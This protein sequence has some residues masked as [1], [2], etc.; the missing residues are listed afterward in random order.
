MRQILLS[1][2]L[3][4]AVAVAG[5]GLTWVG[6]AGAADATVTF[7]DRANP[8]NLTVAPGTRVTFANQSGERMRVRSED[9]PAGFDSGNLEA[10]AAWSVVL[11]APGTYAYV[12]DRDRD[13]PAYHG[14]ITVSP[15]TQSGG[16]SP[17]SPAPAQPPAGSPAA[18]SAPA[19]AAVSILDRSFSPTTVTVAPGGTVSWTNQS[20]RDHTV[21][22]TGFDSG[23][24]GGGGRF[25]HTPR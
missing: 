6:T 11:D 20:G 15:A 5:P 8:A 2:M 18:P 7:T 14:T 9:G 12:N 19:T 3:A 25:S 24:L 10:G 23:V 17:T 22:G 16:G 4:V 21:T 1:F 13:D